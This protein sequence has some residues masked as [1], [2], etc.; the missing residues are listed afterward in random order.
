MF[1]DNQF[2]SILLH[3]VQCVDQQHWGLVRGAE[4]QDLPQTYYIS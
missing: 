1:S 3:D 4:S 2:P